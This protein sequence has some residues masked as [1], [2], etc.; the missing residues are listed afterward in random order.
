METLALE[1]SEI[2]SPD[3]MRLREETP[4]AELVIPNDKYVSPETYSKI[5]L[6]EQPFLEPFKRLK[7]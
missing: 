6:L 7:S 2:Q 5:V 3:L 1:S 4:N